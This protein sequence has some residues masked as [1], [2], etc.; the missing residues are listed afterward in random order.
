MSRYILA[1]D[2]GTTSSRSVLFDQAGVI[3]AIAQQE[4]PQHFPQPGW[5]EHD[6]EQ[7]WQSQLSTVG[8]VLAR[9]GAKASDLAAVGIT[10]QRE[11]TLLW[12]RFSGQPV[13]RA[14]VWQDRR[15]A[16][17]CQQLR[18]AGHEADI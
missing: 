3:V 8:K 9:A 16:A 1:L 10:N 11:T 4:F 12:D 13:A 14:I 15:T 7:L 2:Q 5:V 6:P 18:A 17:L